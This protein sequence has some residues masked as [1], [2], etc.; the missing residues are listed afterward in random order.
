MLPVQQTE[1]PVVQRWW[2]YLIR[3]ASGQL[4]C[5]ISTDVARRL[6]E[7]QGSAKGARALRGKGP[8]TLEFSQLVGDRSMALRLEYRIKRWSK[9]DKEKLIRGEKTLADDVEAVAAD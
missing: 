3:M 5:G 6:K 9:A 7:H 4:Y 8:L 2:L 1:S